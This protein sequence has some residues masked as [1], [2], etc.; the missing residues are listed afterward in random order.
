MRMLVVVPPRCRSFESG[1]R[2]GD[3]GRFEEAR[4]NQTWTPYEDARRT[5][6]CPLTAVVWPLGPMRAAEKRRTAGG[7]RRGLS[8]ALRA[9]CRAE[10]RS[11]PAVRVSQ[12]TPQG[13]RTWGALFL[14]S[15][16]GQAKEEGCCRAPPGDRVARSATAQQIAP[17]N[18]P[19]AHTPCARLSR[20]H[21]V[22][23][24]HRERGGLMPISC[25]LLLSNQKK[26]GAVRLPPATA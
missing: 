23:Q 19:N 25:L 16:F 3:R 2:L 9:L 4:L 12:G 8:E 6:G 20:N 14:P 1:A 13:R 11:R 17:D 5:R 18:A 24:A 22:R 26:K 15:S 21:A 7:I 10:F